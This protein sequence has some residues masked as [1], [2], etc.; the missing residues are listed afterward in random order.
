MSRVLRLLACLPLLAP[1]ACAADL[2]AGPEPAPGPHPQAVRPAVFASIELA[3]LLTEPLYVIDGVPIT[4]PAQLQGHDPRDIETVQ[5]IRHISEAGFS[6]RAG[7]QPGGHHARERLALA[8][9]HS[10]QLP[11]VTHGT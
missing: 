8:A 7:P 10:I 2:V 5:V 6:C 3:A 11:E 4:D 1:A 9:P